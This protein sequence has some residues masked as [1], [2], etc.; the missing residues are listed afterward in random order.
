MGAMRAPT[1]LRYQLKYA[2]MPAGEETL[3]LEKK[4]EGYRMRLV[5]D[6]AL[7]LPKTRQEWESLM[8]ERGVPLRYVERVEGRGTRVFDLEFLRDEGVVVGKDL[9]LPYV[10]DYHDPLSLI[11]KLGKSEDETLTLPMVGGRVHATRL[12]DTELAFP[13]GKVPVKVYRLRP[14]V[15]YVYYDREGRP[16]KFVQ[17]L[18][19]HVFEAVLLEAFEGEPEPERRP[20]RKRRRRKR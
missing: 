19:Q 17:K 3:T 8:D 2:G 15:S 4:G 6:V 13:W 10:V 20:N 9:V 12:P 14:G 7:P 1:R 11:L 5:A 16:V 18:G